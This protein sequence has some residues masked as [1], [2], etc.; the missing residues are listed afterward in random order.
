VVPAQI[1]AWIGQFERTHHKSDLPGNIH[2]IGVMNHE[3][4]QL[5]DQHTVQII[6]E[7]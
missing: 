7:K 5:T 1:S 4:M 3:R 2:S 6:G